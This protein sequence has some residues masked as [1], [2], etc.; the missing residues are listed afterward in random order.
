M[1]LSIF[2]L[3]ALIVL[4]F[5]FNVSKFSFHALSKLPLALMK[6]KRL[7]EK[8]TSAYAG[9]S[10]LLSSKLSLPFLTNVCVKD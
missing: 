10:N 5:I 1:Q 8:D 3:P 4:P 7:E 2:C 6:G 9:Y